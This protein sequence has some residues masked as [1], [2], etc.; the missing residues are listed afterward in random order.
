[1]AVKLAVFVLVLGILLLRESHLHDM[2]RR[3]IPWHNIDDAVGPWFDLLVPAV[4]IAKL[5]ASLHERGEVRSRLR[6][7]N[8][9]KRLLQ[10]S[11]EPPAVVGRM[12][13]P[14][15]EVEHILLRHL[16]AE[17]RTAAVEHK[18]GNP[19]LAPILAV[20]LVEKRQLL[21]AILLRV[22]VEWE[23]LSSFI[24]HVKVW[25]HIRHYA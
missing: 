25:N 13:N 24:K 19:A 10:I 16:V 7:R 21:I 1:M 3:I 12:K 8:A 17:L 11:I 9:R 14:V 22:H 5:A 2:I 18:V 6:Q 20:A 23:A 15:D 4:Q